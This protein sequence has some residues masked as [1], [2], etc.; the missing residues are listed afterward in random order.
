MYNRAS[1]DVTPLQIYYSGLTFSPQTSII[2]SLFKDD[3]PNWLKNPNNLD[4]QWSPCLHVLE[5]HTEA[6]VKV[7]FSPD[8]R[9]IVT[10]AEDCTIRVWDAGTGACLQTLKGHEKWVSGL[11]VSP[12]SD[13]IASHALDQTVRLWDLHSGASQ[14]VLRTEDYIGSMA[15]TPDG[16]RLVLLSPA[17][18]VHILDIR[19]AHVIRTHMLHATMDCKAVVSHNGRWIASMYDDG[20]VRVGDVGTGL[21]KLTVQPKTDIS[22]INIICGD[23]DILLLVGNWA[24][25]LWSLE[26]G[27]RIAYF[28]PDADRVLTAHVL[29]DGT[30][31][32]VAAYESMRLWD[33]RRDTILQTFAGHTE[34]ILDVAISANAQKMASASVDNTVRIWNVASRFQT[35][36]DRGSIQSVDLLAISPDGQQV[37]SAS[38]GHIKLW[39]V[40]TGIITQ[41]I[42]HDRIV[43]SIQFSSDSKH[44]AVS[45]VSGRKRVWNCRTGKALQG[46]TCNSFSTKTALHASCSASVDEFPRA[47]WGEGDVPSDGIYYQHPWIVLNG[48]KVLRVPLTYQPCQ[49]AATD[50][51][52]VIGC[53]TGQVLIFDFRALALNDLDTQ[54]AKNQQPW[55]YEHLFGGPKAL[56]W[57]DSVDRAIG[58]EKPSRQAR[59]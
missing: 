28:E 14:I 48:E 59:E 50:T 23:N 55:P 16:Q 58:A 36:K 19:T 22:L 42:P 11:A 39:D 56:Q 20:I 35:P 38:D 47:F 17:K 33:M 52:A 1:I 13:C 40:Q 5:G 41:D 9:F 45:T 46:L 30:C 34:T 2:R 18:C 51:I 26:S 4:E 27:T 15:F 32:A 12:G 21:V 7:V 53:Y 49:F 3:I 25:E 37:A 24:V 54:R 43:D 8:T 31:V 6:V 29:P 44:I 57:R 10:G